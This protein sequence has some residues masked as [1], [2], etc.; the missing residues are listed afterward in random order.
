MNFD[1]RRDSSLAAADADA[2]LDAEVAVW[3]ASAVAV[4]LVERVDSFAVMAVC[5]CA[6]VQCMNRIENEMCIYLNILLPRFDC[7][8]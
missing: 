5:R 2:E 3:V 4:S 1:L 6:D 8:D 7:I